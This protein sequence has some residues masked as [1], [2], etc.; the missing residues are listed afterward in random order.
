MLADEAISPRPV[1]GSMT[2]GRR[3]P[4]SALLRAASNPTMRRGGIPG[5]RGERRGGVNRLRVGVVGES[6]RLRSAAVR[7]RQSDGRPAATPSGTS[8]GLESLPNVGD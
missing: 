2:Q 5:L 4:L 3:L 7:R 6:T 8:C 1:D